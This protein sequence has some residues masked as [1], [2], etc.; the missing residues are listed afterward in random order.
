MKIV[1][2]FEYWGCFY[3]FFACLKK[4]SFPPCLSYSWINNL[5]TSKPRNVS[6]NLFKSICTKSLNNQT[7]K[8][9]F[10]KTTAL[11]RLV[12]VIY[13]SSGLGVV[14]NS[15]STVFRI[16]CPI[17]SEREKSDCVCDRKSVEKVWRLWLVLLS[18]SF[19]NASV[20]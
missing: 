3:K 16:L 10:M 7:V 5:K 9:E 1:L 12:I 13:L 19:S 11:Y 2:T 15:S 8:R 4:T 6:E 20:T 17:H 14:V 18:A